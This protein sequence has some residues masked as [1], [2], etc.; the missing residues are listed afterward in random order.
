MIEI[1]LEFQQISG[2]FQKYSENIPGTFWKNPEIPGNSGN[3]QK[4][5]EISGRFRKCPRNLWKF[6]GISENPRKLLEYF[7][8][9]FRNF[10]KCPENSRKNLIFPEF[11]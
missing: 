10:Q 11:S 6:P 3:F 5:P 2:N 4:Y 1:P 9:M 7:R 8:N